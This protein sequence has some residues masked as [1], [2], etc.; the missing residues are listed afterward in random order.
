M[1]KGPVLS[2]TLLTETLRDGTKRLLP[3]ALVTTAIGAMVETRS[4]IRN[5]GAVTAEDPYDLANFTDIQPVDETTRAQLG[6]NGGQWPMNYNVS[7]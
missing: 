4:L 3:F 5:G 2:R 1:P 7:P 6:L